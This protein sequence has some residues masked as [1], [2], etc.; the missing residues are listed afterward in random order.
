MPDYRD[1]HLINTLTVIDG[2]VIN[3]TPLRVGIGRETSLALTVD[4][5][6]Y[7]V[8]GRPCIPG[9]SLKGVLRSL[10]EMLARS[11]G[12]KVHD[13]WDE[14]AIEREEKSGNFCEVCGIFGNTKLASHI[15]VYDLIPKNP[16]DI[17]T[18]YKYGVAIDRN[19][20][21]VRSGLGPFIEEF[22]EPGVM[23]TLRMD[24][25]NIEVFPEP[26]K[27][28]VRAFLVRELLRAMQII[29]V[30]VGARKSVGAGLIKLKEAKWRVYCLKNGEF[31]LSCEGAL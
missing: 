9:S 17:R 11:M 6:V 20:G 7:K 5:A 28:D 31:E 29:G 19:F 12:I 13:P 8:N 15:K 23:W 25:L 21:S 30:Q 4:I 22:V 26:K 27:N 18:L 14:E 3:E 24:L 1:F 10:A 2:I 16:R